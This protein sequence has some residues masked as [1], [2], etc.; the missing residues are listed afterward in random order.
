MGTGQNW[1]ALMRSCALLCLTA[2]GVQ[3]QLG[4]VGGPG[5]I[6]FGRVYLPDGKP[7]SR[8]KVYLEM[9]NG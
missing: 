1:L 6:V 4:T 2:I 9:P 5:F 3:A 7:A 8:V